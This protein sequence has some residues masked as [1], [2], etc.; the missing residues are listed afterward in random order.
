MKIM[1]IIGSPHKGETLA[2]VQKVEEQMQAL[3][4]VEFDI[5]WL[6]DIHFK[7]CSGCHACIRFGEEKCPLRDET[8]AIEAR[9]QAA[10]G[11]ILATPVYS[12]QVSYLMK[13]Y[14]DRFSYLWHRPRF[15]GKFVMAIAAGGG[16]FKDPLNYLEQCTTAWGYTCAA[17]LGIAHPDSLVPKM[18]ATLER[19]IEKAAR[20][21]YLAVQSAKTPPPSPFRLIWFRMWRT[22]ARACKDY[23]PA[24]FRYWTEKGWFEQDFYTIQRLGWL[25]RT[26][27]QGMEKL[28]V[29]FMRRIY[30]GY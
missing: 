2:G 26:F 16:Q 22:N 19:D 28:L 17:K 27:S 8:A 3:G 18:R 21:F 10:D 13:I 30:T 24:D 23:I 1:V 6:K 11:L 14:L 29:F 15:F 12:Q 4:P 7:Q 9:M 25:P 5:L 20:R